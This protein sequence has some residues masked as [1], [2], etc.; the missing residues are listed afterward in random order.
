MNN[1]INFNVYETSP[2][3]CNYLPNRLATTVFVDPYFRKKI[4]L[5]DKL[6]QQGF[7]R[8]G[9]HIYR[10]Q[11]QGCNACIAVRVPVKQFVPRRSQRRTWQRN[12]D[13]IVSA[14]APK[15]NPRHFE[16]Y[17]RYLAARHEGDG[18]DNPTKNSYMD[19]LTSTWS[20][21]VFY[22][23]SVKKQLLAVAVVDHL[24]KGLSAMYTFFDPDY[25][26]RSLG[27][28]AVLWEIEEVKRLNLDWLYLG[29][30]VKDCRKMSYK[31][32]YQPLEYFYQGT[33]LRAKG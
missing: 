18:M 20:N 1:R 9:E 23:F 8:S 3:D 25:S 13:L 27:V 10:P 11:C 17:C 28:Y 4:S 16:L 21:T 19:F 2:H 5:Y 22:E 32:E 14:A 6:S 29:Y 7:R 33:W 30:W 15:F 12:Q 26:A 24:E 31:T